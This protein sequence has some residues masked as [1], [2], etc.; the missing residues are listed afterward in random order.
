MIG[1]V[2][3]ASAL[4][5]MAA[6][7]L[8]ALLLLYLASPHIPNDLQRIGTLLRALER[9][10]D[11]VEVVVIGDS[12][13]MNGVDA[14][15]FPVTAY[16]LGT[17]WQQ[18]VEARLFLQQLPPS[19]NTVFWVIKPMAMELGKGN[20]LRRDQYN[21]YWMYGFRPKDE[22]RRDLEAIFPKEAPPMFSAGP[23]EQVI[24]SRW[25]MMQA[26]EWWGRSLFNEDLDSERAAND[27][28][29]PYIF[30]AQLPPDRMQR[31]VD[32]LVSNMGD[33]RFRM[34]SSQEAVIR[35]MARVATERSI[36]LVA[37][38]APLNPLVLEIVGDQYRDDAA[39][40]LAQVIV[41]EGQY[42]LDGSA[43]V[44][45]KAYFVDQVHFGGDGVR[46][47]TELL[48]NF[49]RDL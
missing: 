20:F 31:A 2:R 15:L 16:N 24:E 26:F 11:Q 10:Q 43:A 7:V 41:E 34:S 1:F 28:Y 21:A 39:A 12:I 47:F 30:R 46:Q 14:S 22:T 38:L 3:I 29:F 32:G 35:E 13:T 36:R 33:Q 19:V 23:I 17:T 37:V 27:L 25:I 48:I 45:D 9:N 8:L 18:L 44:T 40:A 5:A 49:W 6:G 42:F 4:L